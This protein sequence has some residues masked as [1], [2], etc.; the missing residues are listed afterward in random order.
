MVAGVALLVPLAVLTVPAGAAPPAPKR[1][2]NLLDLLAGLQPTTTVPATTTT[3]TTAPGGTITGTLQNGSS[4]RQVRALEAKLDSLHYFV[5]RIDESYDDATE[6]A[7]MAFQKTNRLGRTGKV[8]QSV[9][10]RIQSATE[11]AP[12]VPRG[13]A[14]RVEVDLDRQV[15]F[16]YEGGKLSK[17]IAVSTGNGED[18]CQNGSCG[19]AITPTGDFSIY[20]RGT[21]WETGPLGSLYNP[22]YFKG[23]YAI[24]GSQSVPAEPASHGCVRI[25]MDAAEW[26]PDHVSIGTPVHI[27]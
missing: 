4:G 21:G 17:I 18:Y 8:D 22:Q 12:L 1:S 7:V 23:G 2:G 13:A 20:R 15:L 5:G 19:T 16:L 24:H 26:F 27:R 9:W 25:P 14:H 3:T 11:P 6:Q 10:T